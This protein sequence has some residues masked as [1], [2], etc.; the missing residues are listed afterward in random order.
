MKEIIDPIC[1]HIG[2]VIPALCVSHIKKM[3]DSGRFIE[4]FTP[5]VDT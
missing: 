5:M 3:E 4:S 2:I 1:L